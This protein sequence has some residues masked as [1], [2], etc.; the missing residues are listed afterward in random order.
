MPVPVFELGRS[1]RPIAVMILPSKNVDFIGIKLIKGRFFACAYGLYEVDSNFAY[2]Y[3]DQIIYFYDVTNGQPLDLRAVKKLQ[4]ALTMHSVNSVGEMLGQTIM[5]KVKKQNA[6][7]AEIKKGMPNPE[8]MKEIVV[9]VSMQQM[10]EN[11]LIADVLNA[12]KVDTEIIEFLRAFHDCDQASLIGILADVHHQKKIF[13]KFST[14]VSSS[15]EVVTHPKRFRQPIAF[16]EL[17]N[18]RLAI[19]N[20]SYKSR[21]AIAAVAKNQYAILESDNEYAYNSRKQQVY[22]YPLDDAVIDAAQKNE[23]VKELKAAVKKKENVR[24]IIE[25]YKVRK[26]MLINTHSIIEAELHAFPPSIISGFATEID[27]GFQEV[28]RLAQR[29]KPQIPIILIMAIIMGAAIVFSNIPAIIKAVG[30]QL[31]KMQGKPV[32]EAPPQ[33]QQQQTQPVQPPKSEPVK[34]KE[35]SP[36]I[37]IPPVKNP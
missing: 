1:G 25:R 8:L 13:E 5:D 19:R 15:G 16:I 6:I 23:L 11:K 33:Q 17:P 14:R 4:E 29:K 36:Q 22:F 21:Y 7:A 28:K 31:D 12:K 37:I 10:I 9:D 26:P 24:P 27:H 20:M 18:R 3:R 32:P 30:E 34:P 2:K 35:E